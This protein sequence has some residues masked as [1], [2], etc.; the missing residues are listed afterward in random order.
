MKNKIVYLVG[1]GPGDPGL[2]TVKGLECIKKADVIV[3]D[4][5]V[6]SVLLRNARKDVELIYVGKKGNQHTMEQDDINQLLVDKANENKIV[7]RLKGGDPYVFGRGGEE[8][9][10]LRENNILFEVVPGITA[11]IASPNYA[12]IPVT[13]RTCTSTF[14][15]ITGHEDPTKDQSD[16]DWEK[17]STGL[18][19]LTF[20]MGIKNL[21]NIVNQLV[22]H[23]RSKDTPV[24]VIRWGTTTHQQTVTGTLSNIVEVAKDIKPPAITIVGEVVNLRDQLNWFE[25]RPLFGKTIIVTRSRDQ[26]SE[27]SEQLIELGANVL[28]YPTINITSPDDF[29]PLDRELDSLESTDWLIFTS[30]NGVDAFFNRIFE[31][32]RDVRDLKGVKI[33]SIGPS[34]TERIKG[35]HVSIDCQPPKYVAESVVEALKKVEELK[36]KRFLMPRTDIARS[37]VPEELRKLGAEVSDIVAYKTVLATDGD[38]IVLDKLKDG[39]VDIVTF[40]SASTVKNFV[41]IIGEDNLSAFKNN[42]QFASIGPITNESAEEMDIDISIKAEEYTIPG[43]VQAIV[44]KVT[45]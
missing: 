40:T 39:E 30:V 45:Q 26:A 34:T 20:Y 1:S 42:V 22:K 43:L 32:G 2:I 7:T 9:I 17:L 16:V 14:G 11:A 19:T 35:F 27:F 5:L 31:L 38:N 44:N 12:G 41:K 6:N 28:E 13:H 24:A 4:Y 29:G 15:L 21:P 8:A 36:G 37:Y 23:G 18:G 10:V 25:S 33:C 3:Y